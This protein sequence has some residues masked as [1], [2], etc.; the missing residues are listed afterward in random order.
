MATKRKSPRVHLRLVKTSEKYGVVG[1][2]SA[3]VGKGK[4]RRRVSADEK[5]RRKTYGY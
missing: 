4:I 3:K 5:D 1:V 2:R